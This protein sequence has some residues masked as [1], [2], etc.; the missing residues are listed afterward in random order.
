MRPLPAAVE[1]RAPQPG[2]AWTVANHLREADLNELIAAGLDDIEGVIQEGI[3]L[4]ALCWTAT[5]DGRPVCVF[6]VRE[7]EGRGVPWL[8]GT[9]EMAA[10]RRAFIA[11]APAYI[12]LM[13]EAFPV[14]I[15]HVHAK[16]EQA[17]RWLRRAGF[18]L[19]EPHAHPATG[20][21]FLMFT[22]ER[23]RV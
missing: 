6:G 20:E 5:A 14:L 1:I 7:W 22:K 21:A 3:D 19:Q 11:Q 17:V 4:S 10:H 12:E 18:A 15:N 2:D 16:N 13:L 9:Q 23:A 8:L